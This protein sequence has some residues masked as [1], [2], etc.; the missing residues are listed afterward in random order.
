MPTSFFPMSAS[1][2][3]QRYDGVEIIPKKNDPHRSR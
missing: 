3:K 1:F 2:L